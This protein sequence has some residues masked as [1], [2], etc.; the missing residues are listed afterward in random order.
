MGAST[1]FD[2]KGKLIVGAMLAGCNQY[3]NH[4]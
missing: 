3:E 1:L 2:Y 4:E